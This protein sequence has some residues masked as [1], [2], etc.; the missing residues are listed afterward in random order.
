MNTLT[1]SDE[2]RSA[3]LFTLESSLNDLSTEISHTDDVV[4]KQQLQ[5]RYDILG[6]VI[7]TLE[8]D[9]VPQEIR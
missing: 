4:L 6:E 2:Q 9:P 7:Q 5:R 3:L 1:L 8:R